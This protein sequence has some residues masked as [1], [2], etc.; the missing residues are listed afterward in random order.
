MMGSIHDGLLEIYVLKAVN[1]APTYCFALADYL[2]TRA[3]SVRR[4]LHHLEEQGYLTS[5]KHW[6]QFNY[7]ITEKGKAELKLRQAEMR[8]KG[9]V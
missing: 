8:I 9:G 3:M 5:Q 6:R 4:V 1:D 2:G 7:S